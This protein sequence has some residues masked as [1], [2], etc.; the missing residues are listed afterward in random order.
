MKQLLDKTWSGQVS[1]GVLGTEDLSYN[2]IARMISKVL[3]KPIS[4]QA[5]SAL[6]LKPRMMEFGMSEA[7]AQ[8]LLEIWNSMNTGTF[9]QVKRTPKNSS[10]TKFKT[11]CAEVLKPAVLAQ[12]KQ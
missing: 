1:F 8:S 5:A 2:D 3:R 9:N 10:P 11:W 6:E 12:S 7:A 4:Y